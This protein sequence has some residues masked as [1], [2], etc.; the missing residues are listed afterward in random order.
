MKALTN[1]S[2]MG[3]TELAQ[4]TGVQY[5]RLMTHLDWL[6]EKNL[7]EYIVKDRMIYVTL[8]ELGRDFASKILTLYG[9]VDTCD[10]YPKITN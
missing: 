3:R 8:T 5:A 7:T 9:W 2:Y 6:N 4:Q 10:L 1:K